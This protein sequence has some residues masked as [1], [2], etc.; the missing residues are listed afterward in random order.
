MLII[1]DVCAALVYISQGDTRRFIYWVAA[2][3]L[4]ASLTY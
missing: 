4:T 1:L 2:A 3:T